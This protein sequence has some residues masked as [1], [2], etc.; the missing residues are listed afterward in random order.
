MSMR[1]H[2]AS[3]RSGCLAYCSSPLR[4]AEDIHL[5]SRKIT[6]GTLYAENRGRGPE[7]EKRSQ[8]MGD[9]AYI[10]GVIVFFILC[11]LYVEALDRI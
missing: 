1:L 4:R 6:S 10:I 3:R 11:A 8:R 2:D 7:L 5:K 9:A